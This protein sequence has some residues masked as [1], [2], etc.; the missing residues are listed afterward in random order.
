MTA[1]LSLVPVPVIRRL[2]FANVHVPCF[3]ADEGLV[4]FNLAI[5]FTSEEVILHR[6][7]D[8]LEHEPR[9]FLSHSYIAGNLVTTHAVLAIREHPRCREP[10]VQCDRR[11][12]VNRPD[13]D[14]EFAFRVMA[15]ALPSSASRVK[16][17]DLCRCTNGADY[18]VRPSADSDVVDA[19]IGIREVDN[20]FLKALRFW[21]HF[22]A[23]LVRMYPKTVGEASIFLPFN[24]IG[25]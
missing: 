17:T 18:A 13:F 5:Q 22:A 4:N 21:C 1:V 15:P 3:T 19:I 10:L 14:G 16:C 9:R 25:R 2:R 20:R 11:I 7:A 6:K 8:S 12:F 24:G 23:S